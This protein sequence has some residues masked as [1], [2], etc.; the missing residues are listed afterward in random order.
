MGEIQFHCEHCG[1]KISAPDAAGGRLGK[2]P[3]C[4]Q[5]CYVPRPKDE[6]EEIPLAA[7]DPNEEK[8]RQQL[9]ME[10]HRLQAQLL[11]HQEEPSAAGSAK[12]G[13]AASRSA[14]APAAAAQPVVSL[15]DLI[16]KYIGAM[17]KGQLASADQL[18]TSIVSQ[19]KK[20]L[21]RIDD[22]AMTG[23]TDPELQ[24][25]PAN[26]VAGFFRTLR[27]KFQ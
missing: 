22:L 21:Q 12:G 11:D 7:E 19:G 24:S 18:A 25:V 9:V 1:K 23:L 5:Q 13:S 27:G 4:K 2:C 20:A 17:V 14:T 3:Y 8:H 6:V 16:G 26:V 10:T 15:D